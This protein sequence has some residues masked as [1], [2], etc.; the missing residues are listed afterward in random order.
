L[1]DGDN[2]EGIET[3][4]KALETALTEVEVVISCD[5]MNDSVVNAQIF[6]FD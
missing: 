2:L 1:K 5:I 4:E 6:D 3:R